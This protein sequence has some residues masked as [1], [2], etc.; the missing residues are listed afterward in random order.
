MIP[1]IASRFVAGESP[2]AVLDHVRT[3]NERDVKAIVNLLG[4]HY[5]E[6]PPASDDA[7]EYRS[8]V[9]DIAESD[10]EA[11]LSVK[12]SQLGLDIGEDV[13]QEELESIVETAQDHD[14]FVWVDMEDHTTTDTT[15][16]AYEEL[17]REYEGGVGVCV[18][19]NLRRTRDD[20]ERLADVP[21]KVRFVKGAYDEPE[22]VA[23]TDRERAT[24]ELKGLL[25]YAFEHYDGGVGVGSHDPEIVDYA[26]DLYD[27]HGT[28]FE[29]Q[30]L[31][32]VRTDTQ[33]DLAEEY[34]VYQYVPYGSRWKSYFYRRVMERK[35]NLRFALRAILGR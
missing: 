5:D 32:G 15:L 30:M 1:P 8:L 14:V 33:Y 19:A 6:R 20:V 16:D 21:G 23:Y 12:P 22:D 4:E 25:E 18:Q 9:A 28:D 2:A 10:L 31:M 24:E 26:I 29:V 35:E 3:L 13:F 7:A 11:C 34:E 27:E 17:A